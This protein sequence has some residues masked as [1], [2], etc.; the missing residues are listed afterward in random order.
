[1]TRKPNHARDPLR[2]IVKREIQNGKPFVILVC[3]HASPGRPASR[4]SKFYPCI[5]CAAIVA[6]HRKEVKTP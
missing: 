1:M 2:R 4:S 6:A 5:E 3:N